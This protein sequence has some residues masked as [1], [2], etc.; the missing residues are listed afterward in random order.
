MCTISDQDHDQGQNNRV[1]N[2]DQRHIPESLSLLVLLPLF[3]IV[4]I[5]ALLAILSGSSDETPHDEGV[6]KAY[7]PEHFPE[8]DWD[9]P[10]L[11]SVQ[12]ASVL[13]SDI[14]ITVPPPPFSNED[15]FPC[16]ECH[17]DLDSNLEPRELE[18]MHEE[19]TIAHGAEDRWCYDCHNIDNRDMLRLANGKLVS[20]EESYLLCGQCHGTIFRDWRRGI[21]GRRRGYWNGPKSY[22][23]CAH[24]HNP[25]APHFE[26]LKPLPPPVRPEFQGKQLTR[27]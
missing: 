11:E 1:D 15:I 23:L 20:F 10:L 21:H 9:E 2:G 18:E 26:P 19:I 6:S 5:I 12:R 27:R 22:L 16:S 17:N 13:E 7:G 25:H 14:A 3:A 4:A 24:C 8:I